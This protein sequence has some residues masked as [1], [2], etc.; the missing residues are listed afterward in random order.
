MCM[1]PIGYLKANGAP[2]YLYACFKGEN[3]E[4]PWERSEMDQTTTLAGAS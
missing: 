1:V 3:N 4:N 2:V